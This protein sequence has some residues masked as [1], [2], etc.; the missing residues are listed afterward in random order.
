M[1]SLGN[2]WTKPWALLVWGYPGQGY[3]DWGYLDRGYQDLGTTTLIKKLSIL[4]KS[5]YSK[6]ILVFML[7]LHSHN[8]K[9]SKDFSFKTPKARALD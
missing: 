7:P 9:L 6:L 5:L 3:P 2:Q 1:P 8:L 4:S